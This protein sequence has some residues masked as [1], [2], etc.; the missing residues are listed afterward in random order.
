[1]ATT[2]DTKKDTAQQFVNQRKNNLLKFLVA[3]CFSFLVLF[4]AAL[5]VPVKSREHSGVVTQNQET[6]LLCI[7]SAL[8]HE[9]RGEPEEGIRAVMSVIYN[10]KNSKHYPDTFCDVILQDKQFSAFNSNKGLA[11]KRL[12]PVREA[13]IAAYTKVAGIAQ[14]VLLGTF[15]PVLDPSVMH[16]AHFRVKNHWTKKYKKV[17]VAGKHVFY[18]E[19]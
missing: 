10:R 13:D 5:D 11:T 12:K 18:K 14:E 7:K 15:K 9:A 3:F 17:K 4:P 2:M 8:W 19:S 6:E 1:M 16:Y